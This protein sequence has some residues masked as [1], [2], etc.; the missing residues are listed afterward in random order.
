MELD[1]AM[2]RWRRMTPEQREAILEE[3]KRHPRP[4]HG[5]P[6]YRSESRLYLLSAA[7]YK[8]QSIIGVSPQRMAEF[9]SDL[10]RSTAERAQTIFAWIVLPNH[11]HLL[12]DTADI[13]PC[14][15][16]TA[17]CTAG[18]RFGGIGKMLAAVDRSG[19]GRLRLP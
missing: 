16:G 19:T 18:H 4:W 2:Y 3:R 5:P 15:R 8:H 6:H 17:I 12:V 7:C 10:L 14:S 1:H 9:E 11:Y 13:L